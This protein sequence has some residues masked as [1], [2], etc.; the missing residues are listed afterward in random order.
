MNLTKFLFL[1]FIGIIVSAWLGT[2]GL[3]AQERQFSAL[4]AARFDTHK[5]SYADPKPRAEPVLLSAEILQKYIADHHIPL[6]QKLV[7]AR[8]ERQCLTQAIYHEARGEPDAGQWAVGEVILNRVDSWRY[9]GSICEVVYQNAAQFHNC[10]FSFACDGKTDTPVLRTR[11]DR[12]SW[13]KAALFAQI[14]YQKGERHLDNVRVRQD[15]LYYH[16]TTVSPRWASA[17][18]VSTKIGQHIFY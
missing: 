18:Q 14:I 12:Y 7:L 6:P 17:M 9:P 10:Q 3:I 1:N 8:R 11:L 5:F 4:N 2:S 16:A 15:V 13:L